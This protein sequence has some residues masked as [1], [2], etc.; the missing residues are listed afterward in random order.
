MKIK[1]NKLRHQAVAGFCNDVRQEQ[2]VVTMELQQ[3]PLYIAIQKLL[4]FDLL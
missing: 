3:D 2:T 1:D 4:L